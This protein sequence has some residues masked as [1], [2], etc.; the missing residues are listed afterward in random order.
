M[1]PGD[2]L[3]TIQFLHREGLHY[4]KMAFL[5]YLGAILSWQCYQKRVGRKLIA[6]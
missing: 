1:I 2:H 6:R 3:V 4:E 5:T